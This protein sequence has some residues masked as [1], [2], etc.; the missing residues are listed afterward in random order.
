[1]QGDRRATPDLPRLCDGSVEGVNEVEEFERYLREP[2]HNAIA[3]YNTSKVGALKLRGARGRCCRPASLGLAHI[4]PARTHE[5][6]S[7]NDVVVPTTKIQ[8]VP[9]CPSGSHIERKMPF[10]LPL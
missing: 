3:G 6:D 8:E 10:R 4:R 7:N 9:L 5:S 1:M 2:Q